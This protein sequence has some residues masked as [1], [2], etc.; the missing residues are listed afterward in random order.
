MAECLHSLIELMREG[1][2]GQGELS[3]P[4]LLQRDPHVFHEVVH[5][6]PGIEIPV[7]YSRGEI[8][9]RPACRGAAT[10]RLQ[11]AWYIELG[12]ISVEQAF[13][14]S[15]HGAGDDDL[16]AQLGMLAC[17]GAALVDD[18]FS[19]T[20]EQRHDS[21]HGVGRSPDHDGEGGVARA[22]VPAGDR[23]IEGVGLTGLR[24]FRDVAGEG[25][26]RRGHIDH[27]HAGSQ[28]RQHA[29]VSEIDFPHILGEADHREEHIRPLGHGVRGVGPGGALGQD[30]CGLPD[31][32][33]GD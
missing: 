26:F 19:Q 16:V 21:L 32:W 4:G 24:R 31:A 17:A 11:H 2:A 23:R 7:Y 14:H 25:R 12:S 15:D 6:K 27:D 28:S 1:E 29:I 13:T 30:R 5:E 20:L 10:N 22:D 18:L 9:Q 8:V 3:A 33:F